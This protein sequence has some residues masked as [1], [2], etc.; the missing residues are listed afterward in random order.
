MAPRSKPSPPAGERPSVRLPLPNRAAIEGLGQFEFD[1]L[2]V[3]SLNNGEISRSRW[4]DLGRGH[5]LLSPSRHTLAGKDIEEPIEKLGALGLIEIKRPTVMLVAYSVVP[6]T[7]MQVLQVAHERDR[8]VHFVPDRPAPPVDRHRLPAAGDA[9]IDLRVGVIQAN[10]AAI[11]DAIARSFVRTRGELGYWLAMSLGVQPLPEWV[12]RLPSYDIRAAYFEVALNLISLSLSPI[13]AELLDQALALPDRAVRLQAGRLLVVRGEGSRVSGL[14]GLPK[15]G[16]EGLALL[17]AFWTGDF[18]TALAIGEQTVA[19]RKQKPLP[20]L[21]GVCHLLAAIVESSSKPE[22]IDAVGRQVQASKTQTDVASLLRPVYRTLL[23]EDPIVHPYCSTVELRA[24]WPTSFVRLLHDVWLRPSVRVGGREPDRETPVQTARSL[25]RNWQT[26]AHANGYLAVERELAGII[27]VFDGQPAPLRLASGFHPPAPWEAA[28]ATLEAAVMQTEAAEQTGTALELVWEVEVTRLGLEIQARIRSGPRAKKG[29]TV[30]L[31][32]L[33]AGQHAELLTEADRRV[34]ASATPGTN[35]WES[36]Y[37]R[38]WLGPATMLALIGHPRVIGTDG[39]PRVVERGRATIR[40]HQDRGVTRVELEPAALRNRSLVVECPDPQRMVVFERTRELEQLSEILAR[41]EGLAVPE[42]ARERL[43]RAL[44][45]LSLFASVDVEGDLQMGARDVETDSRPVFQLGWNGSALVVR[46]KVAPLG[47][48]GPRLHPGVGA[49]LIVAELR[50]GDA[51]G[52]TRGTRDL[53]EE[54]RR[55]AAVLDL[56]PTLC[57]FAE[58]DLHWRVPDL[59][60]ALD[61]VLELDAL[62]DEVVLAWQVGQKLDVPKRVDSKDFHIKVGAGKT[63]FEVEA[64]LQVDEQ[65]VLQYRE[66]LRGRTGPRFVAL[67][68]GQFVVLS[69]RLRKHLDQLGSLGVAHADG[70]RT[71]PALLPLLEEFASETVDPSFDARTL[72]RLTQLREISRLSPRIPRGFAATLRDYQREGFVWMARLAEAGLGACLADDMGL[73]KTVQALALLAHRARRGPALVVCPTSVVINWIAEA[74]RFA[75]G[76]QFVALAS[77]DDRAALVASAGPRVVVVCSYTML[78]GELELLADVEFSTVIYDEAHA[79]KNS[80]T[81]RAMAARR[82]RAEFR[83]ALTGTPIENHVGELWSLFAAILPGMLGS[84]ASFEERFVAGGSDR[85]RTNRLRAVLRPF[86]LR[87][88]KAQVLDELPPRTEITLRVEPYPEQLAYYEAMRRLAVE[89]AAH[90]KPKQVRFHL[91]AEITRLRQAAVD[92]RLVEPDTAPKGAKLDVLIARLL[93]LRDGGHRAL[94][95]TQFLGSL[96]AVRERLV[97]EGIEHFELEGS[98]PAAERARRIE[99]FQAGEADVFLLSLRAGG[100]G[101][102]L[103]GADYVFHLDPWWNPAVED[104]ASDRAH[105]IG[106]DRPVTVYR[107]VTAGTIEEKILALHGTK[108]QLAD[109][110]LAGLEQTSSLDLDQLRALLDG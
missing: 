73:G 79:L 68:R 34:I 67:D 85:E 56:C 98:T 41:G 28:L 10:A 77:A 16:A 59:Q 21:E 101:V 97:A 46:A 32:R 11:N 49:P 84:E 66:I 27:E 72:A 107:L 44:T 2:V 55:S 22:C 51:A 58:D 31:A 93:E 110:L 14:E 20:D 86:V 9:I 87:R 3:L 36:G 104:Q 37:G 30:G 100:M 76:L 95:F 38:F 90:M 81:Q 50:S 88:L 69:E 18:A 74:Q 57:G 23:G 89:R 75:P 52:L 103:T 39:N 99:A 54:L 61:V 5:G 17:A 64:T 108:R 40:T 70:L 13:S 92:P 33:L 60:S 47:M 19:A 25:A 80:R 105:R 78:V 15:W 62:G 91:L 42:Q 94:V 26:R 24:D 65:T 63:W 35:H 106:Q 109:D 82:I 12:E 43:G 1:L 83:L 48:A 6:A 8:L 71:T 53:A 4:A 45:R 29:Q 102:N 7:A 96:A